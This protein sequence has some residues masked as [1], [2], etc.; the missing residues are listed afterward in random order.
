MFG[1]VRKIRIRYFAIVRSG[2]FIAMLEILSP[3]DSCNSPIR[4]RLSLL[5]ARTSL[6]PMSSFAAG[7]CK[8]LLFS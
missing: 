7:A 5:A 2:P 8:S 4:F 1:E 6:G 3:V